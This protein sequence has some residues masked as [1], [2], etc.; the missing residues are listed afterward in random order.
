MMLLN[1]DARHIPLADGSVH[2]CV[3]SPVYWGLRSYLA[4]DDPLKD[5]ELGA[6]RVHDCLGWATGEPC[7]KCYV[8][9][10]VEVFREV[11]RVLRD[12]GICWLNLGDSYFG[13]K[14]SNEMPQESRMRLRTGLTP[15][16]VAYV[17]DEL[18]KHS[19]IVSATMDGDE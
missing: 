5:R 14:G 12:D 6:E 10:M 7:G 13:G 11:R 16:Q 1:A 18:A 3:T 8:C 4:D 2:C 19:R 15:K 9:H 17:L